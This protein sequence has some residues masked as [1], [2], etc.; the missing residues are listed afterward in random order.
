MIAEIDIF[1]ITHNNLGITINCLDAL[2]NNTDPDVFN[3]IVL[4]DSTDLTPVYMELFQKEHSNMRYIGI[5]DHSIGGAAK[6]DIGMAQTD[7]EFVVGMSNSIMVEPRWL[8]MPLDIMKTRPEIGGVGPKDIMPN[9]MIGNAGVIIGEG[10]VVCIGAN[11]PGY[12]YS[13][14]YEVDAI[15]CGV[16]R[17]KA[18][19]SIGGWERKGY[20]PY[21]T[22]DDIDMSL[23]LKEKGWKIV[24]C[25]YSCIVHK[26]A[27]TRGTL[28]DYPQRI[29]KNRALF[30]SRWGSYLSRETLPPCKVWTLG[31]N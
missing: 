24:Y 22:M 28:P 26:N 29:A 17:R 10:K 5:D 7:A 3:L 4:D 12:R 31:G 20:I 25:G 19:E 14:I 2:Y 18:V 21:G 8:N 11:E 27:A 13:F 1:V 9:G 23:L 6:L 30:E 15:G 16:F